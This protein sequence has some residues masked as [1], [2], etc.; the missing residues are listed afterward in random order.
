MS[1]NYICSFSFSNAYC[2]TT[3]FSSFL[4]LLLIFIFSFFKLKKF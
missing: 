4:P 3:F 1:N 2:Y